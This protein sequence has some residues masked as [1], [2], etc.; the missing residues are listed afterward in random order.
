MLSYLWWYVKLDDVL[1][2]ITVLT[3]AL[4]QIMA[5]LDK[6]PLVTTLFPSIINE[7]DEGRVSE[8]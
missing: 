4:I 2:T 3:V 6:L 8:G 5:I 7:G 1:Y